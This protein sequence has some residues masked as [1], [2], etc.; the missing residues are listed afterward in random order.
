MIKYSD[1]VFGYIPKPLKERL[2]RIRATNRHYSESFLITKG[3]EFVVPS[4]EKELGIMG[5]LI[6]SKKKNKSE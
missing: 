6:T 2:R 5:P 1:Q 3:L 4:I